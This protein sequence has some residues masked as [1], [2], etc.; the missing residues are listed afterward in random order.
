MQIVAEVKSHSPFGWH[1]KHSWDQLFEIADSIGDII[2][3]HTDPRWH[4]SFELVAKARK[5]TTKPILAKGIHSS[6]DQITQALESGANYVLVVGRV[7]KNHLKKCWI[8]PNSIKRLQD[9]LPEQKVVWNARDLS[10]G[11]AKKETF[12]QARQA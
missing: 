8:E 1:S 10:T 12:A 11:K 2:S 4:G 6:D 7:P 9:L 3:I 5:L